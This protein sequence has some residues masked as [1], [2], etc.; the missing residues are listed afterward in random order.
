MDA[1]LK[2]FVEHLEQG[3]VAVDRFGRALFLNREAQAIVRGVHL[4]LVNGRLRACA[5]SGSVALRKLI[6]DCAANACG[7]SLRLVS[8]EATLLIAASAVPAMTSTDSDPIVLLR[9]IDPAT[10]RPPVKEALQVQFG[11]TPTEAAFALEMLAGN[12][13]AASAAR[14]GITL[15]TA[16]VHLRRIFEKTGTRRQAA[17][18]RLLLLCPKPIV[19][20]GTS[21]AHSDAKVVR[22]VNRER[23]WRRNAAA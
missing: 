9:L 13:L 2:A 8:E 16:R 15:N 1:A 3:V 7:G 21:A 6:A 19:E 20:E 17:L 11:L 22:R 12:D 4:R 18:M 5:P 10:V 14:R 23:A